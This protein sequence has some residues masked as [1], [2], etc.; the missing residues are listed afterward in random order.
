MGS[1]SRAGKRK[2][3]KS[4]VDRLR[5][6]E[7][8]SELANLHRVH[9]KMIH[10]TELVSKRAVAFFKETPNGKFDVAAVLATYN[11]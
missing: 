11:Q 1:F 4:S 5:N 8:D 7:N 2:S 10:L 9:S 6:M 3:G